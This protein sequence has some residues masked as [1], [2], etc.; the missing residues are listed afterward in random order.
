MKKFT[1]ISL[2]FMTN[3]G[4]A[5]ENLYVKVRDC[6]GSPVSN[7]I[8]QL[9]FNSGHVVFGDGESR[10]YKAITDSN[11]AAVVSF[12]GDSSE[13]FWLAEADGYYPSEMRKESFKVD[14]VSIPP[15][16]YNVVM[17]EHEKHGE[18]TL[19]KKKNP[20]PMYAYS[21]EKKVVAPTM[22]GR[23]GFDLQVFDWLP[24][25]GEGKVAD[26]YYVRDRKDIERV[27]SLIAQNKS[28]EVHGFRSDEPEAPKLGD[29]VGRIEFEPNCGAYIRNQTGNEN[30]PST[31]GADPNGEY[32]SEVP[33]KVCV[34]NGLL[35]LQEGPI[36][37]DDE[38]M[39]IRSRVQL[40]DR[41]NMVSANYSKI[42]GPWLIGSTMCPYETVF[43]PRPNDTNLEFDPEQNLYK[44]KRGRGRL[45]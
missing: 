30:F 4:C 19:Y 15:M 13:V 20:Q 6:D 34:N 16:Y 37:K 45:P 22:N 9:G 43:N 8:V 17:L 24:P 14:V 26:F 35:W 11:G 23:Y 31:Y 10:H 5:S 27:S 3:V 21:R 40:D 25:Y 1:F 32:R 2:F 33:I 7:A 28:Y 44:G 18:I 42:L 38:Y 36:I 29:I 41:G 12:R 39:V